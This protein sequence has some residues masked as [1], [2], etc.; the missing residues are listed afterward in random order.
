MASGCY[1][2]IS[3][4]LAVEWIYQIVFR[5]VVWIES[6]IETT[7]VKIWERTDLKKHS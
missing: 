6:T 1:P 5:E 2:G 3:P 7:V 4:W